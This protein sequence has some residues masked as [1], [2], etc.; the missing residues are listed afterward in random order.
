MSRPPT[1][2]HGDGGFS[3]GQAGEPPGVHLPH[4]GG[5]GLGCLGLGCGRGLGLLLRQLTRMHHDKAQGLLREP[6]LTVLHFPWAE[7]A[8]PRPVARRCVLRPPRLLD[9][10]GQCGLLLSPG[11]AF[12]PDGTRARDEGHEPDLVLQA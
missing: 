12:L 10:Q 1:L 4:V 3:I 2:I 5:Y 11:F 7:H 6:S 9:E 8:A